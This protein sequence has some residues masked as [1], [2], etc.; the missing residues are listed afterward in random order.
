MPH[1]TMQNRH[2]QRPGN[3]LHQG[4][5]ISLQSNT[6]C[7]ERLDGVHNIGTIAMWDRGS[8]IND[9]PNEPNGR[10]VCTVHSLSLCGIWALLSMKYQLCRVARQSVQ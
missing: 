5:G 2:V 7:G 6:K 10:M 9:T 1:L 8:L 4:F 3:D